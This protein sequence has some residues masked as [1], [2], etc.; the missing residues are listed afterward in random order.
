MNKKHLQRIKEQ[1]EAEERFKRLEVERKK[2]EQD[3]AEA[4]ALRE[5]ARLEALRR[6]EI[7]RQQE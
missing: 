7:K 6:L 5:A 3:E 1:Q 4:A 2:R